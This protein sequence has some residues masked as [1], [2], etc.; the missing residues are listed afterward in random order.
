MK[1]LMA[2]TM[3]LAGCGGGTMMNNNPPDVTM[4]QGDFSYYVVNSLLVPMQRSDY[5]IDLNGDN[6]P[7]NQLGNIIGA[8]SAQNLDTQKQIDMAV[9]GGTVVLLISVQATNLMTAD[10]VGVTVYLGQKQMMPDFMSGMGM[11]TVDGSEMPG[12]FF[13]KISSGKMLSNNPVTTT[14]PVTLTLKLPLIAGADAL[15]LNVNGAHIQFNVGTDSASGKPG[16]LNGQ[17]HGSIKNA[18][19]QNSIIP[20]VAQLLSKNVSVCCMAGGADGGAGDGGGC[21]AGDKQILQIFDTGGCMN[22]DGTMAVAMDCKIDVCE[23]ATNM[24]IMNVLA[25]DVQIFASDGTTYMPN[26]KNTMKDSL[27]LGLGFTAVQSAKPAGAQ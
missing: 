4:A 19:V 20:A 23:V 6:H 9:G 1:R 22:P 11:F 3:I 26:P 17:L 8:L 16:L 14:H 10:N 12:H 2:L 5:A 13:G 27:S 15:S 24:I 7:D 25:P 18:D 21:T